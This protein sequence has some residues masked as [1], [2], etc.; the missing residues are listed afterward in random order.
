MSEILVQM[1]LLGVVAADD[2]GESVFEA[3]RLGDFEI[4]ALGVALF[5]AIVDGVSVGIRWAIR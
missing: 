1:E 5:H 4:E 3:E 2:H